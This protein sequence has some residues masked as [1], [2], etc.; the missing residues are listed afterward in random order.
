MN[1]FGLEGSGFIIAISVCLLLVGAVVYYFNTRVAALE[2]G[3]AQNA[4]ILS[5][6]IA[7][8]REQMM[9]A[10]APP[11][12]A[13][14]G[15]QNQ[16]VE[17]EQNGATESA[18]LAAQEWANNKP[19]TKVPVSEGSDNEDDDESDESD[20]DDDSSL[21]DEN[22]DEE[23]DDSDD[24][25]VLTL[26][27]EAGGVSLEGL[28]GVKSIS[29]MKVDP[30]DSNGIAAM[31]QAVNLDGNEVVDLTNEGPQITE[32][33]DD[34]KEG[35]EDAVKQEVSLG[36]LDSMNSLDETIDS[37]KSSSLGS[38]DDLDDDDAADAETAE[39]NT[40]ANADTDFS[41]LNVAGLK[42]AAKKAGITG[43]S[44]MKKKA[45]QNALKEHYSQ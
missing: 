18:V 17:D 24:A 15:G 19:E 27:E 28:L 36:E 13:S 41:K 23:E 26:G 30:S 5:N 45:L 9:S 10:P 40:S 25:G 8:Y 34:S 29:V 32:I 16:Y 7:N 37:L 31:L 12:V 44:S 14:G 11:P 2:K 4:A 39:T 20:E 21:D 35:T 22:S 33:L 38:D 43:Y 1:M 3:L 6:F 42:R